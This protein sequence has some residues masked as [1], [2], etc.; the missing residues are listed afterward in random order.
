MMSSTVTMPAVRPYSSTTT[1]I[2]ARSRW[3]S[4]SRSSSGFVS[5]TIRASLT[6]PSIEAF[7]PSVISLR[8]SEFACTTPR[9]R[10]VLSSSVTTRRVWPESTQRRSAAS[11]VSEASQVTTAGIGVIT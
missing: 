1:A 2:D 3:R 5:G 4:A 10:S 6:L 8:A 7:G 11:A 9:M